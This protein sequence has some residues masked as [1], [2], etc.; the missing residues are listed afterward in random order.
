MRCPR[1]SAENNSTAYF[2]QECAAALVSPASP[3]FGLRSIEDYQSE[4]DQTL[5][6][7]FQKSN[8]QLD[9]SPP[10]SQAMPSHIVIQS[11]KNFTILSHRKTRNSTGDW[12][13]TSLPEMTPLSF[14]E[15][16]N[17]RHFFQNSAERFWS[18]NCRL[19][20]N[21]RRHLRRKRKGCLEMRDVI[22]SRSTTPNGLILHSITLTS[23]QYAS[24]KFSMKTS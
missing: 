2:C 10:P 19:Y 7:Y 21:S 1:C 24:P 13:I 4:L 16:Y 5:D 15:S 8:D 3:M 20:H 22:E 14:L 23:P 9:K 6:Q 11:K 12:K 18:P 17:Y